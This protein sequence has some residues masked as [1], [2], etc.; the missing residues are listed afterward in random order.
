MKKLIRYALFACGCYLC[1]YLFPKIAADP[2]TFI[3]LRTDVLATLEKYKDTWQ[4][5]TIKTLDQ[6]DDMNYELGDVVATITIPKM[7]IFEQPVYYGSNYLNNNWQIT[8]P[9]HL[10]NWGL[11]GE[12]KPCCIGAHNYQLF[13]NLPDLEE[14]DL[15]IVE[16]QIDTYVYEVVQTEIYDHLVDDF[17]DK[18]YNSKQE[19]DLI[20]MTCWPM[21]AIET[22]DSYLVTCR[23]RKGT[24]LIPITE[25]TTETNENEG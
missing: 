16:N 17:S 2:L 11:L 3:D 15:V 23:M 21:D 9:G 10:S 14:G 4:D 13:A 25:E 5:T 20:L 19:Y 1:V 8:M 22:E 18:A 6:P 24:K 7:K 12:Y